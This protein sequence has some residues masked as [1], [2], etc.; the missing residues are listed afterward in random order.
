[1][2]AF[3]L[4]L[5]SQLTHA[6]TFPRYAIPLAFLMAVKFSEDLNPRYFLY[7]ILF[8]VYQIFCGVYL[9]FLLAIP[10]GFFLLLI[11][12][13]ESFLRK[14]A[15][16]NTKWILQIVA[17]TLLGSA[18]LLPLM[19][20]YIERKLV[21]THEHYLT[22]ANTIPTIQSYFFSQYGSLLWGFLSSTGHNLHNWWNH[23]IFAGGVATLSLIIAFVWMFIRLIKLRFRLSSFPVLLILMLTALITFL[24]FIRFGDAS[25][26]MALYYLPGFSSMRCLT[27]IINIELIFFAIA[28]AYV[29]SELF[30]NINK[31]KP[32]FFLVALAVLVSDNYYNTEFSYKSS[33]SLAKE[34]IEVI[35]KTFAEIP[36]AS[37]V[38]YEPFSLDTLSVYYQIDAMLTAQK[39]GL[40][41]VNGY[42]ATCPGR[43]SGY[44]VDPNETTRNYWLRDKIIPYDTLYVVKT[45]DVIQKVPVADIQNY[46]RIAALEDRIEEIVSHIKSDKKW[47]TE[48]EEK[49]LQINISPDSMLRL[50]A[51]WIIQ[52][53]E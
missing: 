17:Y 22:I 45:R 52:H 38:S 5:Q 6:Q 33:V 1:V 2:F 51:L 11:I 18:I 4:A 13:K 46:C 16:F 41:I 24:L 37:L 28:T 21:P 32:V 25:A 40:K 9:G 48:I 50:D 47:M 30:N 14:K 3:S 20:P 23:Q 42:T 35:D 31:F 43:F 29:F 12:I 15:L 39:Y 8:V 26:Y 49:A 36:K 34:R 10:V 27:R 7:S 19:L 53:E 44:W